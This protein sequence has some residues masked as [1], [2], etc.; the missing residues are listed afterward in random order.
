MKWTRTLA[1]LMTKKNMFITL[2][3][4]RSQSRLHFR[5]NGAGPKLINFSGR[6]FYSGVNKL[7][8]LNFESIYTIV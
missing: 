1:Y 2:S 6:Y 8:R 4:W 3:P 5:L 7:E